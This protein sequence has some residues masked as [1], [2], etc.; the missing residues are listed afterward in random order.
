MKIKNDKVEIE[1]NP[2]ELRLFEIKDADS[3]KRFMTELDVK[4]SLIGFSN[5]EE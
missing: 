1:M 5:K 4:N 2:E 3:L